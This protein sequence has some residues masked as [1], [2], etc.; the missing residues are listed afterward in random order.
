MSTNAIQLLEHWLPVVG[1][2][3]RYQVSNCGSVWSDKN[4]KPLRPAPQS[5]GYLT[6]NLYDGSSPKKSKSHC[7]HDLV[8]R[9]FIGPKP[10]GFHVDHD[11]RG[12]QYNRV[13]NI[14]YVTQHENNRRNVTRGK[15]ITFRGAAHANAK[16]TDNDVARIRMDACHM[17][18][19]DLATRHNVSVDTIRKLLRGASYQVA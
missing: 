4:Q 19:D 3:G 1:Y 15:I 2:E 6:V 14:E 10:D 12:K 18:T 7:V 13:S 5:K 16:L 8:A 17:R 9:A 11:L